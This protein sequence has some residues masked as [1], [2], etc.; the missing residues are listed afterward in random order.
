MTIWEKFFII[1]LLLEIG[2]NSADCIP[3]T[4]LNF[5]DN[6]TGLF[7]KSFSLSCWLLNCVKKF[8]HTEIKI[9]YLTDD[10]VSNIWDIYILI[11]VY[12][13]CYTLSSY[14]KIELHIVKALHVIIKTWVKYCFF[15]K[16]HYISLKTRKTMCG[17]YMSI[18]AFYLFIYFLTG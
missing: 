9:I 10:I 6:S 18:W 1:Q 17:S 15:Y 2:A 3:N 12:F 4:F 11:A 8:A 7:N 13:F 16:N 14:V 5:H